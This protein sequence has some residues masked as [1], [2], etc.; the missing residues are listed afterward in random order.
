V[1]HLIG[2]DWHQFF[3]P[4]HSILEMIVRGTVMYLALFTFLRVLGRRQSGSLNT[5]DVLVI[6]LLADAAQNG[7]SHEY[8]SVT[9]GL[10]LVLTILAW[11]FIIDWLAFHFPKLRPILNPPALCLVKDGVL[12]RRNMRRELITNDELM[13]HL[14]EQGVESPADVKRAQMEEDGTISVIKRD[15]R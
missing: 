13:A 14:R 12:Q 6:V 8:H 11:D 15:A 10:T 7:M 4:E 3:I 9:E 1:E 5:A 2:I